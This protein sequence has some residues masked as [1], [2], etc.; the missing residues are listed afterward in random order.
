MQVFSGSEREAKSGSG[1]S[2]VERFCRFQLA[3][4]GHFPVFV[5]RQTPVLWL[6][7]SVW[8]PVA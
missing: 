5:E 8:F 7:A 2:L 3:D 1:V 6:A 4:C